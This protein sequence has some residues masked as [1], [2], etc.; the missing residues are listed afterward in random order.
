M[1][2]E[3]FDRLIARATELSGRNEWIIFGSQA[4]HALTTTPPVEVLVSVECYIWLPD[5]PE[6]ARLLTAQLGQ[7]SEF[8]KSTGIY[9][10]LLPTA[11]LLIPAGWESRLVTLPVG[12]AFAQCL[13]ITDLGITKLAAGRLKDYEFIAAALLQKLVTADEIRKRIQTFPDPHT[14]A[15][16]LARLQ[17]AS[18]SS[19]LL[20]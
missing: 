19:D 6:L 11:L 17:I 10:D 4:V 3:Q 8:A 9:A 12:N 16:L 2:R 18:D 15:V 1:Q 5:E 14:Q 7:N 20:F 13:E